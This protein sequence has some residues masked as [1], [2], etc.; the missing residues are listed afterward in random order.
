MMEQTLP[1]RNRTLLPRVV[2]TF[3]G[4]AAVGWL[5]GWLITDVWK[6][7]VLREIDRPVTLFYQ[8]HRG[9]FWNTVMEA[10]TFLGTTY[11]LAA[12]L[13]VAAFWAFTRRPQTI[14]TGFLVL[15]LVGGT[16]LDNLVK[17][18]VDRP[19]PA[20]DPITSFSHSS[21]PSGHVVSATVVFLAFAI[22]FAR[23]RG[24]RRLALLVVVALI[25]SVAVALS[26][27]YLGVHW[28]TDVAAGML[29]AA[30]W[31]GAVARTVGISSLPPEPAG[32]RGRVV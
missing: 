16:S 11:V 6:A 32:R 28:T 15:T 1:I 10:I 13:L 18:L 14:V 5:L 24:P 26:R 23:G 22:V 25:P 29:L 12:A 2:L 19:R 7:W 30:A 17:A 9:E 8:D 31:T 3:V 4:L 27:V 21:F 20:F